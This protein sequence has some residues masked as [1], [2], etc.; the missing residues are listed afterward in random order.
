MARNQCID[1][2]MEVVCLDDDAVDM[3]DGCTVQVLS[4]DSDDLLPDYPVPSVGKVAYGQPV[5]TA[6]FAPREVA[7]DVIANKGK[8][9]VVHL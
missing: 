2:N 6:T 9:K 7:P 1:T 4:D 3:S 8:R 5:S